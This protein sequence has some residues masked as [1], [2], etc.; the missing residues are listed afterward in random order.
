M[1]KDLDKSLVKKKEPLPESDDIN[2]FDITNDVDE[3]Q[4]NIR[5]SGYP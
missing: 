1:H 4:N 3:L 2:I 5:L